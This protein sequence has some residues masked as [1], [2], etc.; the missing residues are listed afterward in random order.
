MRRNRSKNTAGRKTDNRND[1]NYFLLYLKIVSIVFALSGFYLK[2]L[3]FLLY[4][5]IL[6]EDLC[7][8]GSFNF[9]YLLP[10]LPT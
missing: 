1:I 9:R 4:Y 10:F 6:L 3:L 2:L 8:P 7:M 5:R